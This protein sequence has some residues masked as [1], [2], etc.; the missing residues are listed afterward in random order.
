MAQLVMQERVCQMTQ[1]SLTL[2]NYL[3]SLIKVEQNI[4]WFLLEANIL[5]SFLQKERLE[6]IHLI[7]QV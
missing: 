7:Y 3:F 5:L 2:Q 4:N 1:Q 6:V